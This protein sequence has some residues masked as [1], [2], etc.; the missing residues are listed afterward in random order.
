MTFT[1]TLSVF[2][3]LLLGLLGGGGSIL[4]VPML[5][6]ILHV[7]PK[8]AI[9]TSFVVVGISSLMALVPHARKRHVCWKSGAWF[10]LSGMAG[11]FG[12]GR[13][14]AYCSG[15]V[16]M[17]LFGLVTLVAGMVMLG[18]RDGET[19]GSEAEARSA[20]CPAEVPYR[21]VLFDGFFVGALT[22]L[23]GV[24]GGFLI[25]PTLTLLVRL[26]MSAAV[27]TS[28]LVVAM[29]AAAGLGGYSNHA[30][31][32]PF[33]T[34]VVTG[35]TIAG[36]LAGAWLSLRVAAGMLRRL[37]GVFVLAVAGYV[38]WQSVTPELLDVLAGMLARHL[39]FV[40]G[41][42]ALAVALLLFR[43]GAWIHRAEGKESGVRTEPV[44]RPPENVGRRFSDQTYPQ[45]DRRRR[46]WGF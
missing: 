9:V 30:P 35:G 32:D 8:T 6:Y 27:G 34:A 29:N 4:T 16:L 38:L 26:P 24:G 45:R 1:L 37:F 21:R 36:S 23:V 41:M 17:A 14:A 40:L 46:S 28:L 12:G 2:I 33:L 31:I 20:G 11:A 44:R 7:E 22:G 15:D 18:P 3:G 25:V 43:I 42:A 19:S 13:L 10:G 39:E 5:V